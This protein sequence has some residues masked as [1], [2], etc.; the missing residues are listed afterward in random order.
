MRIVRTL[1]HTWTGKRIRTLC[2]TDALER[3]AFLSPV[4]YHSSVDPAG[5]NRTTSGRSGDYLLSQGKRKNL[6]VDDV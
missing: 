2:S 5:F 4:G 1:V 3:S 6:G